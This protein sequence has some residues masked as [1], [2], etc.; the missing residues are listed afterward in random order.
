MCMNNNG[1]LTHRG[2]GVPGYWQHILR[3]INGRLD[4]NSEE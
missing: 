2:F 3:A 1:T 4:L